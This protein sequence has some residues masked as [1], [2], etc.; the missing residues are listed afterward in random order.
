MLWSV[1]CVEELQTQA[2]QRQNF[3]LRQSNSI[4]LYGFGLA[5]VLSL[6][7]NG[8]L[9]YERSRQR[10]LT[11]YE[12]SHSIHRA[13]QQ[14]LLQQLSDCKQANRGKDSRIGA[15]TDSLTKAG[16]PPPSGLVSHVSLHLT[17]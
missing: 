13:E 9:L 4:L 3:S 17:K 5:L 10:N 14:L 15:S 6:L 2:M 11:E 8:F 16:S 1:L 7:F 12:F